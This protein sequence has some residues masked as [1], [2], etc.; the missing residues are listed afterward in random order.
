MG[1]KALGCDD[2]FPAH[3]KRGRARGS[4]RER[5]AGDLLEIKEIARRLTS[6]VKGAQKGN[7]EASSKALHKIW[8]KNQHVRSEGGTG[9]ED[10]NGCMACVVK[11]GRGL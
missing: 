10:G 4:I 7:T 5:T 6:F 3:Q 1:G 2:C 8:V 11:G 9:K